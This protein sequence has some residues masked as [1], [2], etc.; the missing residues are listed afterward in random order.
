MKGWR[1]MKADVKAAFL[2]GSR[3][4]QEREIYAQ[5]PRELAHAMGI[6]EGD[7]IQLV[8]AAYGMPS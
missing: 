4:Q 5:A 3:S 7:A 6:R 2:Q 1:A 8:K